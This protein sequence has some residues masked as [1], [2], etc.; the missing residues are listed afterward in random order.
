MFETTVIDNF[1]DEREQELVRSNLLQRAKWQFIMDMDGKDTSQYPSFGF[2]HVFNHPNEGIKSEFYSAVVNLFVPRVKEKLNLEVKEVH[3]A[4]SFLQVPLDSK[5]HK[6]RNNVH[7]DIPQ[8]HIAGVYYVTDSDG[9]TILYENRYGETVTE[10]K[11]HQTVTP[12]AGRMVFFDGSRYHC[13]SQPTG[14]LRCI[15][16]MDLIV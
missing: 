14:A 11:R 3:Y 15:I 9:D 12:K 1:L 2:V 4:R 5:F 8:S 10:L 16:N 7:V 13:S 6:G